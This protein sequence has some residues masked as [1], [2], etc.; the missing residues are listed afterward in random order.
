MW[1]A[2]HVDVQLTRV[3][4]RMSEVSAARSAIESETLADTESILHRLRSTE[5]AKLSMLQ[6]DADACLTD[7][8][9]IDNFYSA[10]QSYQPAMLA[11]SGF[12]HATA[13]GSDL[14][15]SPYDS[16]QALEFMRVYPELCAEADRLGSRHVKTE[17]RRIPLS[18]SHATLHA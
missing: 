5:A 12:S 13:A 2:S 7:L 10:L 1:F 17:V 6:G 11:Q 3:Q 8:A 9:A 15:G 18:V 14:A 16:R 4:S